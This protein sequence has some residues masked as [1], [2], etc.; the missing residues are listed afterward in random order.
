MKELYSYR[1][2]KMEVKADAKEGIIEGYL[3]AF[4]N[5]DAYNDVMMPGSFAKSIMERGPKSN[6][7]R[8]K[9][10]LNHD[11]SK[12][13][14]MFNSLEEDSYGL[15]YIAKA[16]NWTLASDY[17][18]MVEGGAVTE[19]SIGYQVMKWEQDQTTGVTKLTEV[20]LWEGSGLTGWGV[21][22]MTPITG[23]KSASQ[24]H[25]RIKTLEA[26]VRNTDAT[27]DCIQML[28]LE[29]KQLNQLVIDLQKSTVP[30]QPTQPEV[31]KAIDWNY[32]LHHI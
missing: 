29:I 31:V 1:S 11:V 30:E 17:V 13:V 32:I 8:I 16:G 12:P 20:K 15:K 26:F 6:R 24:Y 3:S 19:H 9:Y 21:N 28:M 22:E 2:L 14:G 7:P 10:L 18:K 5:I 23:L 27:D 4:G 25:D